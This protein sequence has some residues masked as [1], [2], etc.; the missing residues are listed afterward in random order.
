MNF[1]N[2]VKPRNLTG[3]LSVSFDIDFSGDSFFCLGTLYKS[4]LQFCEA[5]NFHVVTNDCFA[6]DENAFSSAPHLTVFIL[7][8]MMSVVIRNLIAR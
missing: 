3:I 1:I 4:G 2:I 8:V 7:L 5:N 6:F